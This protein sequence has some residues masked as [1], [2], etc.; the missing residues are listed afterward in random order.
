MKALKGKKL[1]EHCNCQQHCNTIHL[2]DAYKKMNRLSLA[3]EGKTCSGSMIGPILQLLASSSLQLRVCRI[4]SAVGP[5]TVCSWMRTSNPPL[6]SLN[7][8]TSLRALPLLIK[9]PFD[10]R[11]PFGGLSKA[12]AL[13]RVSAPTESLHNVQIVAFCRGKSH[14]ESMASFLLTLQLMHNLV[15]YLCP[16]KCRIIFGKLDCQTHGIPC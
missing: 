10:G 9:L 8:W 14:A 16:S 13:H 5:V 1:Q 6:P 4:L 12:G 15:A 2:K 7:V 11:I 3:L